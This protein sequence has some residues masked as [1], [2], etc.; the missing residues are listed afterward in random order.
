M[1]GYTIMGDACRK[2]LYGSKEL[3]GDEK[4]ELEA[5]IKAY[6][7]L[8]EADEQVIC[9]VFESSAFNDMMKGYVCAVMAEY[10]LSPEIQ[11]DI[12]EKFQSSLEKLRPKDALQEWEQ[13]KFRWLS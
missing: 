11:A 2:L 3:S 13:H 12:L 10:N 5:K 9:A 8:K 4:E 7:F 6:D 1:N